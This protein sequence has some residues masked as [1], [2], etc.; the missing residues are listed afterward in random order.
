MCMYTACNAIVTE[1]FTF[2]GPLDNEW[3]L[4]S[5]LHTIIAINDQPAMPHMM[6]THF[7]MSTW[8]LNLLAEFTGCRGVT[9]WLVLCSTLC[10]H[11]A[12][13]NA[14]GQWCLQN[15]PLAVS[16]SIQ[17]ELKLRRVMVIS[18]YIAHSCF[19]AHISK[20]WFCIPWAFSPPCVNHVY[21]MYIRTYVR[22]RNCYI[23]S[24]CIHVCTLRM[25]LF[26][27]R[28]SHSAVP[29]IVVPWTINVQWFVHTNGCSEHITHR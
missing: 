7:P 4:S 27:L 6:C 1:Q 24:Y 14:N 20:P 26:W 2:C 15:V 23:C 16:V 13:L 5:G 28:N 3:V 8:P 29:A 18:H 25:L 10:W 9:Y 22:T 19:N 17:R 12:W 11:M 21:M